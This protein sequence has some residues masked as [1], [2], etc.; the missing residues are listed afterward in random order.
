M[1]GGD[2]ARE[3]R[4]AEGAGREERQGEN[5]RTT[6]TKKWT[7]AGLAGIAILFLPLI[8][9]TNK[10]A[11]L[12]WPVMLVVN[13]FLLPVAIAAL[14]LGLIT[15]RSVLRRML[16]SATM[17]LAGRSSYAF[18]LLHLPVITLLG[19]PYLQKY[20]GAGAGYNLYVLSV[21]LLT[22]ALSVLLFT[23]YEDPLNRWIRKSFLYFSRRPAQPDKEFR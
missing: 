20:F 10:S 5:A 15:E 12:R 11:G 14:Y 22:W 2:R 6:G 4:L 18:Y 9:V 13:N 17:R 19:T 8:Y 16:S 23:F 7:L 3:R 1:L 21:F